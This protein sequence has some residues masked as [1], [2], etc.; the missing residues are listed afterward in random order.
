[1]LLRAAGAAT[2]VNEIAGLVPTF[3]EKKRRV[4]MVLEI[5]ARMGAIN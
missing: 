4:F 2:S 1:M 5:A 3:A